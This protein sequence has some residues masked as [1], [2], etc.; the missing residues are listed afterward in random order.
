MA[1]AET[2]VI[3]RVKK[4]EIL[5]Q[6]RKSRVARF[7]GQALGPTDVV[8]KPGA[9]SKVLAAIAEMGFLAEDATSETSEAIVSKP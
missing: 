3:L 4:P 7:L 2:Q 8:I 9:Q 6:L 5:T 1:R